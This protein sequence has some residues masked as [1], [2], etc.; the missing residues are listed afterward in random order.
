MNT[1]SD[2]ECYV[3][4]ENQCK[5]TMMTTECDHDI[6][7]ACAYEWYKSHNTCCM[8]RN[9]RSEI[10]NLLQDVCKANW[11]EKTN[12][13]EQ[14]RA[15]Y[16]AFKIEKI[17]DCLPDKYTKQPGFILAI[18]KVDVEFFRY[19]HDDLRRD[20]NFVIKA[21]EKYPYFVSFSMQWA[22]DEVLSNPVFQEKFLDLGRDDF[23]ESPEFLEECLQEFA[24]FRNVPIRTIRS[25]PAPHVL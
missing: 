13:E 23:D 21:M 17:L 24:N 6:C 18:M 14:I 11:M 2:H 9:N 7:F 12:R 4:M 16:H 10:I 3:C 15:I 22:D 1:N 5:Y 19:A 20:L 8:C 25:T